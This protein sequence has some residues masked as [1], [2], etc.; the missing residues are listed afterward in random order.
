MALK[1]VRDSRA[2]NLTVTTVW[3][4]WKPACDACGR[5]ES[6]LKKK[7]KLLT[8]SGCLL[9]KYCSKECQKRDWNNEHKN[10]CHLFEAD[11]KL[12]TVF[13]KSLGTGTVNDPT[14]SL[15]EKMINWNLLNVYNHLVIACAALNHDETLAKSQTVDVGIFLKLVGERT[16]SKYDHRTFII[17]KVGLFPRCDTAKFAEEIDWYKGNT[18]QH[19]PTSDHIKIIVGFCR[20][21]E[22][23]LSQVQLWCPSVSTIKADFLP[24]N[25]DLH[26]YITHV[27]RG[28]THFHASF[29]PL[30]RNVLMNMTEVEEDEVEKG[31]SSALSD[32]ASRHHEVLFGRQG[33]G[34]ASLLQSD[35]AKVPSF[36]R[37]QSAKSGYFRSCAPGETDANDSEDF[38]KLVVDPSRMV[39]MLSRVIERATTPKDEALEK[40]RARLLIEGCSAN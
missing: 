10:R 4:R 16:N 38:K 6:S 25:F 21:P 19:T 14:L 22:V 40:K 32:Y 34:V 18:S 30:P 29:W 31:A 11:R 35:G 12:S 2:P 33:Q 20:L 13:A 24:P 1:F 37:N 27:N 7:S 5:L 15:E 9:A 3:D 39:R 26:R 23:G 36:K 28:I 8:C 17:D